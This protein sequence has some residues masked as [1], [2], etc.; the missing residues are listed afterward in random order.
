LIEVKTFRVTG[1]VKKPRAT[2]PF[3]LEIRATKDRDAIEKL[4]TDLGSRHKATRLE[5]KI[6]KIEELKTRRTEPVESGK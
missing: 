4:Y 3:A 2:I 5:I 6:K 1:E